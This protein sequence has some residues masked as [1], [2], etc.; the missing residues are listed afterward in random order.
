MTF[1]LFQ[2]IKTEQGQVDEP[3]GEIGQPQEYTVTYPCIN[4]EISILVSQTA[5]L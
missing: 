3:I 4:I 1:K 2:A 5:Q